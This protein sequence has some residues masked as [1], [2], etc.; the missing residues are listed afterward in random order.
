MG[1]GSL[2]RSMC[3]SVWGAGEGAGVGVG[4]SVS[5]RPVAVRRSVS[6]TAAGKAL[7]SADGVCASEYG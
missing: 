2:R 3:A 7:G 1:V 6:V 4:P 5:G